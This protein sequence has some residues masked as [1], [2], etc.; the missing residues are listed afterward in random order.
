MFLVIFKLFFGGCFDSYIR[1]SRIW[2]MLLKT[3]VKKKAK[4]G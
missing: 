4:A 2:M 3:V 1:L